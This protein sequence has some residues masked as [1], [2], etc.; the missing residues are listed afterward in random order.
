MLTTVLMTVGPGYPIDLFHVVFL[1]PF[2]EKLEQCLKSCHVRL[3]PYHSRTAISV[4]A[5]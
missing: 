2:R 4:D 5:T 3:L 1:S